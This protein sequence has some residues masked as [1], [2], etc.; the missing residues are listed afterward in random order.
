M[1][2][3]PERSQQELT[4][5]TAL[6]MALTAT[7]GYAAPE[8]KKAYT[9]ARELCRQIEDTTRL[10]PVLYGLWGFYSVRAELQ[11]ARELAEQLLRLVRHGL[12]STLLMRAHYTLGNT[13]VHLGELVTARVHLN[14]GV[15]LFDSQEYSST[16]PL[17]EANPGVACRCYA[18]MALWFLGYPDQAL[19]RSREAADLAQRSLTPLAWV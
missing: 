17:F 19:Q 4:L 13:L 18:A 5:Q 3:S 6:G 1:P 11:T 14:Q 15:G 16:A 9:R 8:V 7:K 10:F 12:D 2:D